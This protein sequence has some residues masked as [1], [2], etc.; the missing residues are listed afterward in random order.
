MR[1]SDWS[2]DVCSSDLLVSVH[3]GIHTVVPFMKAAGGGSI[4]NIS[5]AAGLMGMALTSGYGAA[6]WGVRGLS[7]IA[8][9]ELG[10]DKIRVNSV[11]PGMVLTP[12]TAPTGIS[13]EEGAFP[14]NP[15]RRVGD[16]TSACLNSSHQCAH[17]MPSSA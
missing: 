13:L 8:A 10:R 9:V 1:I 15:Y 4:V 3:T 12:M 5:S 14:N 6:K 16:R 17:R 2:S 11:H 7:K